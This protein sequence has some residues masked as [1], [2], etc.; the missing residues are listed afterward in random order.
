VLWRDPHACGDFVGEK[1]R[2]REREREMSKNKMGRKVLLKC[3]HN[4]HTLVYNV[5]DLFENSFELCCE[6][7]GFS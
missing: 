2:E 1:E 4:S 7:T 3:L 5:I 6:A